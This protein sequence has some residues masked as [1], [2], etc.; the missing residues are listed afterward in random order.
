M[1]IKVVVDLHSK[2]RCMFCEK[3]ATRYFFTKI[4]LS[5]SEGYLCEKHYKEKYLGEY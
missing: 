2:D 5:A 3:Q 1:P 4:F